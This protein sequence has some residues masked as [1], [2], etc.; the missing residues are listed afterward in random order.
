MDILFNEAVKD[1]NDSKLLDA[2]LKLYTCM[3]NNYNLIITLSLLMNVLYKLNDI[4][5]ET[6]SKK[7]SNYMNNMDF[8]I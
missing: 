5:F 6:I 3:E 4:E 2:K 8:L 7:Y 1:I